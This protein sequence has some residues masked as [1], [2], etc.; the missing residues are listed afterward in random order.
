M[1]YILTSILTRLFHFKQ[2]I[3]ITIILLISLI[4]FK[5]IRS[6]VAGPFTPILPGTLKGHTI[7]LFAS[8]LKSLPLQLVENLAQTGAQVLIVLPTP[9]TDP[10]NIQIVLLLRQLN[11]NIF[12]DQCD[13]RSAEDC[14]RFTQKWV[15]TA[16][17]TPTTPSALPTSGT[18]T[19]TTT[20]THTTLIKLHAVIFL[21]DLPDLDPDVRHNI[22]I[23]SPLIFIQTLLPYLL[24]TTNPNYRQH[25]VRI[26][27]IISPFHSIVPKN[28]NQWIHLQAHEARLAKTIWKT[29]EYSRLIKSNSN[30]IHESTSTLLPINILPICIGYTRDDLFKLIKFNKINKQWKNSLIKFLSCPL[31][32]LFSKNANESIQIIIWVLILKSI[33]IFEPGEIIQDFKSNKN[34]SKKEKSSDLFIDKELLNKELERNEMIIRKLMNKK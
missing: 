27:P 16:T 20:T 22:L 17:S 24:Q 8:S 26:I 31:I 18:T 21:Y 15:T 28:S 29:F 4:L 6:W 9:I 19:T 12:L 32:Y 33:E 1:L 10:T 11:P 30:K 23:S 25:P 13:L 3:Q 34:Q 14:L 5:L 7:I 2:L